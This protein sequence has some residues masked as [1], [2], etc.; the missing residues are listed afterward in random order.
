MRRSAYSYFRFGL[1]LS[2][3]ETALGV[4]ETGR[5]HIIHLFL[6]QTNLFEKTIKCVYDLVVTDGCEINANDIVLVCG[7]EFELYAHSYLLQSRMK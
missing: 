6:L 7:I 4:M 5:L 2:H 3:L 1:K